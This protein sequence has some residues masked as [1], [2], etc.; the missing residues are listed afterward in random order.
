MSCALQYKNFFFKSSKSPCDKR[1]FDHI[2]KTADLKNDSGGRSLD[3]APPIPPGRA[4]L[5]EG[6]PVDRSLK[7]N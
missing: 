4:G 6:T 3:L 7:A 5:P 1:A 2:D